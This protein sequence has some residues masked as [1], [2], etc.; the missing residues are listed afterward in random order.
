MLDAGRQLALQPRRRLPGRGL[1]LVG[2]SGFSA[3]LFLDAMRRGGVTAIAW[4]RLDAA[5]YEPAASDSPGRS[6]VPARRAH[7][8]RPCPESLRTRAPLGGP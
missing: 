2:D 4:L 5:L 1:V 3:L 6:A 7:A 8:C